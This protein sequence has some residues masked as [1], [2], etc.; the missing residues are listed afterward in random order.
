MSKNDLIA[1]HAA[2]ALD[3]ILILN[4][5][6]KDAGECLQEVEQDRKAGDREAAKESY[7]GLVSALCRL[8]GHHTGSMI[9]DLKA[10]LNQV[11]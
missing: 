8:M 4:R 3:D 1:K 5:L 10:I 9:P 6:I 7:E 11:K 2:S